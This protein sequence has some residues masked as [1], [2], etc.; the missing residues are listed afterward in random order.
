MEKIIGREAE[1]GKLTDYMESGKS[2][3]I[4]LYGRRHHIR[5]Q[6]EYVFGNITSPDYDG[7]T[8]WIKEISDRIHEYHQIIMKELFIHQIKR[9]YNKAL[10]ALQTRRSADGA[11][12]IWRR[13][14]SST[15]VIVFSSMGEQRYNYK[16]SLKKCPYDQ[17]FIADCW[18]RNVSYYWYESKSDH[19]ERY[20]QALINN[21]IERGGYTSLIT[22][23]SS[24]GGT[25]A[26][27]YGLK[28]NAVQIFA[29]ACQ[30]YVGEYLSHY[31][32][33]QWPEQWHAVVGGE[34]IQEWIDIL[35]QKLPSMIEAHRR[36]KTRLFLV[37]STEEHTYQEHVKPLIKKLNEC[38]IRHDD[39]VEKYP[40]HSMIGPYFR[41]VINK[42]LIMG[43]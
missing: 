42:E 39:Q 4:A 24:K 21:I 34:P 17:L 18:A 20:T 9:I 25:A 22:L 43:D 3:F 12:Y 30:Y 32:Y 40:Q 33:K 7:R 31:Q 41:T 1:F 8:V 19:P 10:D 27:Y 5:T 36:C 14:N 38:G 28:Y 35:D 2:E 13:R 15:L 16:K 26:I 6:G 37:Y 23:G 11:Q 29:G